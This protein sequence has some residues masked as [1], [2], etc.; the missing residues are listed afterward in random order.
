MSG[1]PAE[2]PPPI[3]LPSPQ[4][5]KT[6]PRQEDRRLLLWC[7]EQGGWHT[8]EWCDGRWLDSL[9]LTEELQ[10]VSW[11]EVPSNASEE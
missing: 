2:T 11:T 3:T 4:P 5:I 7:P 8:G 1:F 10:P 6:A 9:T